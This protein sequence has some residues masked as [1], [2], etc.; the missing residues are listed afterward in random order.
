MISYNPSMENVKLICKICLWPKYAAVMRM[1]GRI[2]WCEGDMCYN[3]LHMISAYITSYITRY[4]ECTLH[5]TSLQSS[6]RSRFKIWNGKY[7]HTAL[8]TF[9]R[10]LHLRYQSMQEIEMP[11][12]CCFYPLEEELGL[13]ALIK[14]KFNY[15]LSIRNLEEE[16]SALAWTGRGKPIMITF[17]PKHTLKVLDLS[18]IVKLMSRSR[19]WGENQVS[20]D[21]QEVQ[22]QSSKL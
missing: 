7:Y 22:V 4:N 5:V 8:M 2:E 12:K 18:I 10:N 19:R 14:Q 17:A 20:G 6:S 9:S 16:K 21:G 15:L 3:V 1:R 13:G 11:R